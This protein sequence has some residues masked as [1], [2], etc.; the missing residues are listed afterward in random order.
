MNDKLAYF[1]IG[2]RSFCFTEE[3]KI[4]D[5]KT[6]CTVIRPLLEKWF[7]V[8][9]ME[10]KQYESST[11]F[12]AQYAIRGIVRKLDTWN[13]YSKPKLKKILRGVM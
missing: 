6:I 8:V 4:A 9:E 13:G 2:P 7:N 3:E 5:L 1:A 11:D 10:I 12:G